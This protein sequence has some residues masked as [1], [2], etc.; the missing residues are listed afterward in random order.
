MREELE[1]KLIAYQQ[2]CNREDHI[3]DTAWYMAEKGCNS[4]HSGIVAEYTI[5][6]LAERRRAKARAS[7]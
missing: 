7:K 6:T 4:L 2:R 3:S 5:M 1:R